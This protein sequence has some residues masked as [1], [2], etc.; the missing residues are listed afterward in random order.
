M[1]LLETTEKLLERAKAANL[2]PRDVVAASGGK[3]ELEWL[4]KFWQGKA[5]NP[6]VRRVQSL[7]DTL[8]QISKSN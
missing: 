6:T 3:V 7:H 8:K 1:A 4:Y 2:T 5:K